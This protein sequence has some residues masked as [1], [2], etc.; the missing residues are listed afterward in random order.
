M[1]ARLDVTPEKVSKVPDSF[2][3]PCPP[4]GNNGARLTE[5]ALSTLDIM[6]DSRVVLAADLV[7]DIVS[8]QGVL[9]TS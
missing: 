1:V 9:G 7:V 6:N 3:S 2:D 4:V 5:Q 8:K